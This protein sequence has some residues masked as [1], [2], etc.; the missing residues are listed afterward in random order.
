M[1]PR[2]A[3]GELIKKH[4]PGNGVAV[5][6]L[7]DIGKV[8]L[9]DRTLL[10]DEGVVVAV[11]KV[12]KGAKIVGK[13]ELTSRGFVFQQKFGG[14]LNDAETQLMNLL[15]KKK[16]INVSSVKN[17]TNQFLEK[18]FFDK[19]RRKPMVLSVVVEL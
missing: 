10:G 15:Q 5:F 11:V 18:Y 3:F 6:C 19:T 14:I 1:H 16:L 4:R 2:E 8:V 17:L 7:G 12:N 13:P 9:E